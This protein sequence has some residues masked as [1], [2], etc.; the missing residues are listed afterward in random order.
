MLVGDLSINPGESAFVLDGDLTMM[1]F[2]DGSTTIEAV[3]NQISVA[4]NAYFASD[5]IYM[6]ASLANTLVVSGIEDFTNSIIDG[7]VEMIATNGTNNAVLDMVNV[8]GDFNAHLLPRCAYSNRPVPRDRSV[9]EQP[10]IFVGFTARRERKAS[11]SPGPQRAVPLVIAG[12][13]KP[14]GNP[15]R[16]GLPFWPGTA[17]EDPA[18][19]Q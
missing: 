3:T 8:S 5:Y 17:M 15:G 4:P 14:G 7:D 11:N 9:C 13:F 19:A 1:A 16:G 2:D 18:L 12:A 6:F 10:G